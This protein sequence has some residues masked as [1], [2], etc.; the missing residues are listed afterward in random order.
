MDFSGFSEFRH[1]F[2]TGPQRSG[3][4]YIAR[5]I[6]ADTNVHLY[7]DEE[8]FHVDCL[9]MVQRLLWDM[10]TKMVIQC[11]GLSPWVH[12]LAEDQDAVVFCMRDIAE[13]RRSQK[14]AWKSRN[15]DRVEALKYGREEDSAKVKQHYWEFNQRRRIKNNFTIRFP[16]DVE[17]RKDFVPA[18]QRID[19]MNNQTEPE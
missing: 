16:E 6:A 13:V 12:A 11:P 8:V 9:H 2:V 7:V 15:Y 17:S 3:T 10:P 18:E 5:C 1:V 19:W 4:R 14:R